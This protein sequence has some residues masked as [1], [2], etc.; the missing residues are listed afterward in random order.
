MATSF[1]DALHGFL[2]QAIVF[3]RVQLPLS[4]KLEMLLGGMWL[5]QHTSKVFSGVVVS[6]Q[7]SK[8][9]FAQRHNTNARKDNNSSKHGHG[10]LYHEPHMACL[11]LALYPKRKVL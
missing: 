8:R 10:T 2:Q 4:P 7:N 5:P 3:D 9:P 11:L 1:V 6:E